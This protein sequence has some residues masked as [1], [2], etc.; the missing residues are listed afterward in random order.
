MNR[1]SVRFRGKDGEIRYGWG[2]RILSGLLVLWISVWIIF[3]A[4][5]IK[6]YIVLS[7]SMEPT[8][9]TGSICFVNTHVPYEDI[10]EG[11]V[12]AFF[13]GGGM[14]THRVLRVTVEG[15]ETKGDANDR[16]DGVTTGPDNFHG[17][18]IFHIPYVGYGL[19]FCKKPL[20]QC[21]FIVLL[22]LLLL[23][24]M[25]ETEQWHGETN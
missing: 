14:V 7:G 15:L 23:W 21:L 6:S 17:K 9:P 12:I 1:R 24:D 2:S 4:F 18:T 3:F 11:D 16:S 22:V 25:W 20:I 13:H 5:G 8:I 10:Q 19:E